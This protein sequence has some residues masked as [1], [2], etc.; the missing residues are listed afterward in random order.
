MKKKRYLISH[1]ESDCLFEVI[2]TEEAVRQMFDNEPLLED[3]TG[4]LLYEELF[5]AQQL[6]EWL[7]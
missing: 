5:H 7:R 1:P 3:V 2:D 4:I 6:P